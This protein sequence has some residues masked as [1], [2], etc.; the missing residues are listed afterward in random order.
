[1]SKV[2][3]TLKKKN[4]TSVEVFPNIE[5]TNIPDG[6]I[7]T[8]KIEDSSITTNK[9]VDSAVTKSKLDTSI[10]DSI[11]LLDAVIDD[12][13]N[14]D[15]EDI[16]CEKLDVND[17]AVFHD[18][19]EFIKTPECNNYQHYAVTLEDS[20][21]RLRAVAGFINVDMSAYSESDILDALDI[22]RASISDFAQTSIDILVE[23]FTNIMY[24]I[25]EDYKLSVIGYEREAFIHYLNNTLSFVLY[26]TSS[27][28][29]IYE[30]VI[31]TITKT[32]TT[33]KNTGDY[34][35]IYLTP[36]KMFK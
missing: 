11:D 30:L 22:D 12:T 9:I 8:A 2:Y 34:F 26:D 3:E 1:M 19:S 16:E 13:H 5:R 21:P 27:S 32:V 35:Y 24:K 14:I 31:D 28:T 7:N 15:A 17:K 23:L 36:L 33:Y 10:Q 20:D 18:D 6:A 4:D 25:G 29:R